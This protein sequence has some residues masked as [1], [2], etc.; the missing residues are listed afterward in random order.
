MGSQHIHAKRVFLFCVIISVIVLIDQASFGA[1]LKEIHKRGVLRHLGVPYANFVTGS[2]DGLDVELIELFAHYLGVEYQYVQTS[3]QNVFA[4]LTGKK[5]TV[6]GNEIKVIGKVPVRGDLIANGLTVLP[7]RERIV[8]FSSPTFPTQVWLVSRADSAIEPI[9][10]THQIDQDI[11]LVKASLANQKVLGKLNTSLDP[12]LYNLQDQGAQIQYMNGSLNELAP[13]V[14]NNLAEFT[15]LDVPDALIA[16]EKWPGQLKVIGPVS[17][18]QIMACAF[19]KSSPLLKEVFNTFLDQCKK[20]GT[21]LRLVDK[22]Y[23]AVFMYYAEFF[24]NM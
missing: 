11:K 15:L 3:W 12:Q 20:D 9:I 13:A 23:P 17:P 1:D 19:P 16:L 4:D 21:Y 7:W 14:M 10:P 5:I 6:S 24:R 22:Y 8:N 18:Q 2:G